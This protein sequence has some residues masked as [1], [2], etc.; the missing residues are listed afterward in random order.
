M[1]EKKPIVQLILMN[2]TQAWFK[3]SAEEK[4]EKADKGFKI[5]EENGAKFI[6]SGYCLN[7]TWHMFGVIEYPDM[8][9]YQKIAE[10]LINAESDRYSVV[11]SHLGTPL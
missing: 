8:E 11:E 3:L 9:T 4:K 7:P 1:S 5:H 6:S 10:L 2:H